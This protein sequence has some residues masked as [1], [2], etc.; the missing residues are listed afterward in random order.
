MEARLEVGGGMVASGGSHAEALQWVRVGLAALIAGQLMAFSLAANLSPVD[1]GEY[2]VLHGVLAGATLLV[3]ALVGGPLVAEAVRQWGERRVGVEQFFLVGI[4]GAL[5]ASVYA[6][7]TGVGAVFYE[8]VAILLAIYT[9]GRILGQR[10]R[11]AALRTG[12]R[13]RAE[14]SVCARVGAD[15]KLERVASGQLC[16][17]DL[18]EVAA[19]EVVPVDGRLE[20]G[21]ALV[22]EGMLTGEPFPVTKRAG[23]SI[24]A[25]SRLADATVRIRAVDPGRGRKVDGLIRSLQ[26][27]Q[28]RR[29]PMQTE[30]DRLVG[31]F[32]PIVLGVAVVTFGVWTWKVGWVVGMFNALAVLVVACPCA[33][34]LATP[35][36]I[37]GALDR[38]A[39]LGIV[40]RRSG[41]V[42]GLAAVDTVV[43]DK[44]GTLSEEVLA[45]VDFESA[46]G[47]DRE[48][49]RAL[50]ATVQRQSAHPVARAFGAWGDAARLNWK[51]EVLETLP[52]VGLRARVRTCCGREHGVILGN[53]ALVEGKQP[54]WVSGPGREAVLMREVWMEVDGRVVGVARLRENLRASARECLQTLKALGVRTEVMTGDRPEGAA[55]LG[56]EGV[57]AGLLPDEK[58]ERVRRLQEGGRRVCFVGDGSNDSGALE[59]ADVGLA[60][61]GG[62]ALARETAAG[63]IY[64]VNLAALPEALVICRRV[65]LGIRQNMYFAIFY[66]C[67]GIGLAAAG[68]IHPVLAAILMLVSSSMVTWR[69]LRSV[70]A[71][72]AEGGAMHLPPRESWLEGQLGA[73]SAWWRQPKVRWWSWREAGVGWPLV[74]GA[75]MAAQ[76]PLLGWMSAA[77]QAGGTALVVAGVLV[78]ALVA[79]RFEAWRRIPALTFLLGMLVLGQVG[80]LVG[81]AA[82]AGFGPVVKDGVCLCGCPRSPFGWGAV[83][84]GWMQGGML[85]ASLPALFVPSAAVPG[86]IKGQRGRFVVH[87]ILCLAGMFV[88]MELAALA[89]VGLPV[90]EARLHFAVTASAM[91]GGMLLGMLGACRAYRAWA[92]GEEA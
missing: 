66:N 91:A 1:P 64:G 22:E 10:R 61:T 38:L 11:E 30:A 27:A 15:G 49:L 69:A 45:V 9:L 71:I 17:G 73:V 51:A 34:G 25:G 43:F 20:E 62:S 86:W 68:I 28:A 77:G 88:G 48:E 55:L 90:V 63:E 42:D 32:L 57:Q 13:L 31:W 74:L 58:V 52:G 78:G 60:L 18:I 12:E 82:D 89:L 29:S 54:E 65:V 19:G 4:V 76:G 72:R 7:V 81:W 3:F 33:M 21:L 59:A 16:A 41:L 87:G 56:L 6:S 39:R 53:G 40:P 46:P 50:I 5:A 92:G 26:E 44:T 85:L 83:S 67:I 36:G 70:E 14:L 8:V 35:I 2:V 47:V 37:W 23:D 24:W 79:F 84:L 80:M 75:A